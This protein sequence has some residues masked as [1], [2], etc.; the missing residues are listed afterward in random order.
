MSFEQRRVGT[1][2]RSRKRIELI[3]REQEGAYGNVGERG[4]HGREEDA[5]V[6]MHYLVRRCHSPPCRRDEEDGRRDQ[7]S[8]GFVEC[9]V[10]TGAIL[11]RSASIESFS[12]P[13]KECRHSECIDSSLV[14][15]THS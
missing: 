15:I 1:E 11:I 14:G 9:S 13:V 8:N 3:T 12:T 10:V 6:L 5:R 2:M 4:S 7:R